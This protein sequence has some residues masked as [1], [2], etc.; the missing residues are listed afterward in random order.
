[1]Q[2]EEQLELN[3]EEKATLFMQLL[4]KRRKFFAAKRAKE[5][6]NKPPTQA[7]KRKIMSTYLK[8]MEGKKLKDMKNNSKRAGTELEQESFKKQKIDDDKE[9][10]ELKQLVKIISDEEGVAIDVIPLVVK[11]P[12]IMDWKIHKEGKNSY[13]QILM[14][15]GSSNGISLR[16]IMS[17]LRT[18]QYLEQLAAATYSASVAEVVTISLSEYAT[19]SKGDSLGYQAPVWDDPL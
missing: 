12:R 1:M 7:Q 4:E 19:K 14:A 3:D 17:I 11:P 13:Y 15:D 5:K 16:L 2:A 10:T 9:T 8:N 6:R 18:P